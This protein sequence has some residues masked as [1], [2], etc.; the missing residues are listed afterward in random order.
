MQEPPKRFCG[1]FKTIS[2]NEFEK[3]LK[4][5]TVAHSWILPDSSE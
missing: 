3:R 4:D 2:G 5:A 1:Y